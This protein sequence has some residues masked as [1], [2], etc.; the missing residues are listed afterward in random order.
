MTVKT[1]MSVLLREEIIKSTSKI[2]AALIEPEEFS[3]SLLSQH[4]LQAVRNVG[5]QLRISIGGYFKCPL[6]SGVFETKKG[7]FL[8]LTRSHREEI[9]QLVYLEAERLIRSSR[10]LLS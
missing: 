6:C 2:A 7:Y 9:L 10:G 3:S 5:L 1:E 4:L 8:H